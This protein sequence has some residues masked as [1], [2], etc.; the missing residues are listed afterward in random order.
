MKLIAVFL[1][2]A[3][4][5]AAADTDPGYEVTLTNNG[6]TCWIN[7]MVAPVLSQLQGLKV[8]DVTGTEKTIIGDINYQMS[9]ITV[10]SLNVDKFI[11]NVEA[12]KGY[13]LIVLENANADITLDWSYQQQ[14]FPHAHDAGT[15]DAQLKKMVIELHATMVRT[16]DDRPQ[17][18][19]SDIV[20]N[21]GD[22]D[23]TLHG[24][25]SWLYDVFI[26]IF[27]SS[28]VRALNDEFAKA[29]PPAV[30]STINQRLEK[31]PRYSPMD[32]FA[33][34]D[35]RLTWDSAVKFTKSSLT[36]GIDGQVV[37]VDSHAAL[38]QFTPATDMPLIH[39][40]QDLQLFF[41]NEVWASDFFT[42]FNGGVFNTTLVKDDAPSQMQ[43]WF[44]TK[45]W[46]SRIPGLATAHPNSD[47]T[48][49]VIATEAPTSKIFPAA[50]Y[51]EYDVDFLFMVDG[52]ADPVVVLNFRI[53]TAATPY[54]QTDRSRVALEHKPYNQTISVVSSSVGTV[55]V[56]PITPLAKLFIEKSIVP[57]FNKMQDSGNA[58]QMGIFLPL[59]V[60]ID[61]S[62][63][64]VYYASDYVVLTMDMKV[65]A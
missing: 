22:L 48:F 6:L 30:Q 41:S 11:A 2:L 16:D 12:S 40:G 58:H 62:D 38:P 43:S 26:S 32:D 36:F 52:V 23:L 5:F 47:M 49:K 25:A 3:V 10:Q 7:T 59:L 9:S 33:S 64:Q 14:R 50:V 60:D 51:V 19:L 31:W 28:V 8:P 53:G 61:F 55:S 63:A 37:D 20:V 34:F 54:L 46:A 1:L 35:Q 4:C 21:I 27:K 17:I 24:G 56:T 57:F 44:N 39:N 42:H 65:K 45:M 29:L 18:K 15:A 13:F